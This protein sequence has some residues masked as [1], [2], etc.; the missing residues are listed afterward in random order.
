MSDPAWTGR[1]FSPAQRARSDV[2]WT[3]IQQVTADESWCE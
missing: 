3:C 1:R 2:D